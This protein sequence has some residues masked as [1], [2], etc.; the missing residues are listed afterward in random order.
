M[1]L[2]QLI[3]E[4]K[5]D[6]IKAQ[7]ALFTN[8][9][10]LVYTTSLKYCGSKQEAEDHVHDVF[11]VLFNS[12]KKYKPSGSFEGWIKRIT[13][14]KAIDKYKKRKIVDKPYVLEGELQPIHINDKDVDIPLEV[15][16]NAIQ[17]LPERYRL[18]FSLYEL[19]DYS[20]KEIAKMLSISTGTSKSNLHRAKQLLK[21]K[22]SSSTVVDVTIPKS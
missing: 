11:I 22:L 17:E 21:K 6:N 8:Y 13:V 16:F 7:E 9:K 3:N 19:D 15:I 1:E 5:K 20:H 12:I 4:C 2:I 18:V 10:D 14:Y